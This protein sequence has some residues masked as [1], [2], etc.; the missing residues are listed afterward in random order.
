MLASQ[1]LDLKQTS[2]VTT[3]WKD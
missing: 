3:V 2:F 1:Q